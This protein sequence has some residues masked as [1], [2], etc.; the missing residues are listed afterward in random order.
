MNLK[1]LKLLGY[2]GMGLSFAVTVFSNW[3][4]GKTQNIMLEEMVEKAVQKKLGN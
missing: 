2:V 1:T 4:S 3:V